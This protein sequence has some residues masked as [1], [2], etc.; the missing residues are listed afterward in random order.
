MLLEELTNIVF[1]DK[2]WRLKME[3]VLM[4][5]TQENCTYVLKEGIDKMEILDKR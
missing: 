4:V 5:E 1:F 2:M 3:R